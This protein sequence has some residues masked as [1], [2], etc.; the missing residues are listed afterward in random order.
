MSSYQHLKTSNKN[1]YLA[2]KGQFNI[3]GIIG[4]LLAEE[5]TTHL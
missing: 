5:Q 2:L 4:Y 1:S 3:E